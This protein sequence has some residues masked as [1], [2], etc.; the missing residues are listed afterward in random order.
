M[1]T[2]SSL[3]LSCTYNNGECEEYGND[4]D[5]CENDDH[6]YRYAFNYQDI[7]EITP[8]ITEAYLAGLVIDNIYF[9]SEEFLFNKPN[10]ILLV[11][12][13]INV[14]YYSFTISKRIINDYA[15][16]LAGGE[17]DEHVVFITHTDHIT[18]LETTNATRLVLIPTTKAIQ[19]QEEFYYDLGSIISNVGGFVSSLTGFFVFLFGANKLA[20]WGFFQKYVF[21]CLCIRYQKKLIN[22]L[23]TK[24]EPI[25][26]VSGR[27][28]NVTL[29]ERVQ[30][31][32]NILKEYY[33]DTDF[34]NSLL[35][36]HNKVNDNEYYDKV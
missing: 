15:Y 3:P 27:T 35:I 21:K 22:K 36:K 6:T 4:I 29:E 33:L 7:V 1:L 2:C 18:T 5:A 11:N 9:P 26:F 19:Y 14:I 23:K 32:E 25:P 34:L 13:Q 10:S 30:N 17:E 16:G 8:F 28:K 24:Y 31:I 20:P 12:E